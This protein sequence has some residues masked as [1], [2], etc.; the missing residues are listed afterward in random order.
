MSGAPLPKN[1]WDVCSFVVRANI[2]HHDT[3]TKKLNPFLWRKGWFFKS[4]P[5]TK[6]TASI[7]HLAQRP[8]SAAIF[9]QEC[10]SKGADKP[11]T[12]SSVFSLCIAQPGYGFIFHKQNL[13]VM[14]MKRLSKLAVLKTQYIS[15]ESDGALKSE[16]VPKVLSKA[17]V[18]EGFFIQISKGVDR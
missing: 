10:Q 15:G 13:N 4:I 18:S 7:E 14:L 8:S 3:S 9:V 17:S 6:H 5:R 1:W 12:S 2:R 16:R 11:S